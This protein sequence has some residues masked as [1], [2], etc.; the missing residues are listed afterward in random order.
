MDNLNA[1]KN[2]VLYVVQVGG[3]L[4]VVCA[5]VALM[6]S[7]VNA[8]TRDKIIENENAQKRG[9]MAE[10]FESEAVE[11]TELDRIDSDGERVESIYRVARDGATV[12]YCVHLRTLG[13]GGDIDMM[14]ALTAD[15]TVVGVKILSMSETPGLGSQVGESDYLS[16]FVGMGVSLSASDVDMVAG[17]T[18]SSRA[19]LNGI[20]D[21]MSALGGHLGAGGG[22][23]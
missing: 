2:P 8:F 21:A 18:K 15:Q 12:G 23:K 19:V 7:L 13:F 1:K 10:L 5:L 22:A 20:L 16:Q 3:T 4:L 6:L 17:A 11:F 14:V 9:V